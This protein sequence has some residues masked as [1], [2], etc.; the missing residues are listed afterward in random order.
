VNQ[1]NI[2]PIGQLI[3]VPVNIDGMHIMA[4]FEV[5]EIVDDIQPYPY[6]MGMEWVVDN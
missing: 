4:D 3:G 6:L 5:I 2:V 1:H